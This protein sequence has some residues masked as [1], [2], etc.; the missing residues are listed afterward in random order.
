MLLVSVARDFPEL[1]P[2]AVVI[3]EHKQTGKVTQKILPIDHTFKCGH[4][5]QFLRASHCCSH[6]RN[7]WRIPITHKE[8]LTDVRYE[9]KTLPQA[10]H[11]MLM[12]SRP[13][14]LT[15]DISIH[16]QLLP[17]IL[18]AVHSYTLLGAQQGRAHAAGG[19]Q[20]W[21]QRV[22]QSSPVPPEQYS[23]SLPWDGSRGD[24]PRATQKSRRSAATSISMSLQKKLATNISGRQVLM[25]LCGVEM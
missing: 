2:G 6:V 4:Q 15:P 14:P 18:P 25:E 5:E 21:L 3:H 1:L 22:P 9:A 11:W 24:N 20:G 10:K 7:A 17:F 19:F 23:Y 13:W 8:P 16:A 12:C